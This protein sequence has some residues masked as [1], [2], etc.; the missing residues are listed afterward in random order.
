MCSYQTEQE[1]FWAGTFGDEYINRNDSLTSLATEIS[2]FSKIL[3]FTNGISSCIEFGAN[4]GLN[5]K[6]IDMLIPGCELSAVEINSKAVDKLREVKEGEINVYHQSII[7]FKID[8][9]RDFVITCGVLIHLNPDLLPEVYDILYKS[10]KRYI[11]IAEYYNPTPV[12][13]EYRGNG[14][15]LFKRDFAGEM[16]DRY[17]DLSLIQYG[18]NYHRDNIFPQDDITWFLLS[19]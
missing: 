8:Y 10:S 5:L 18:F 13:V 19:K 17:N 4:I 6:A 1:K 2:F 15:K 12:E 11:L 7:D 14:G 3:S 9:Q 16:L